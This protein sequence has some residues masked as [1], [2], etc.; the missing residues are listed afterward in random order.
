MVGKQAAANYHITHTKRPVRAAKPQAGCAANIYYE[1]PERHTL[2]KPPW[3]A[4]I[5]TA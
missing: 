3:T 1:E 4:R 2:Y 5:K